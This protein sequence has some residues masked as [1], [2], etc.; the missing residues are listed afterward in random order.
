[1]F[2]VRSFHITENGAAFDDSVTPEGEI[3][4][5][6]RREYVRNHLIGV[7]RAISEGYDVRGYFLWTLMDNWEWAEGF[8]KRFG[9]VRTDYE[10]QRRIPEAERPMVRRGGP[11]E[12]DRLKDRTHV[13]APHRLDF[14]AVDAPR[15][16]K[17]RAGDFPT[18]RP[19]EIDPR[20][21]EVCYAL[22]LADVDGDG[23]PDVVAVANDAVVWYRNPTWQ[24]RDILRGVT[25]KDNVCLQARDV[26]GDGRVDFALGASWQPSNTKSRRDAAIAHADGVGSTTPGE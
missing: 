25:E 16:S 3:L 19:Q 4:D 22:T 13:R 17:A 24:K 18:F 7:H 12:P 26:D 1:M 14:P 5:L 15:P 2:G 8:T 11:P 23:K 10:T 21:G 6:D 9:I 20:V